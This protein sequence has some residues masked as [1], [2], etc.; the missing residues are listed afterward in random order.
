MA[1]DQVLTRDDTERSKGIPAESKR[2][3]EE[4]GRS[5]SLHG[6]GFGPGGVLGDVPW[7]EIGRSRCKS[8]ACKHGGVTVTLEGVGGLRRPA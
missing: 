8:S 5:R 1:G 7:L 3:E 2:Q 6:M 4:P